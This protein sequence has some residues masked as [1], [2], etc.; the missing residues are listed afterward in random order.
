LFDVFPKNTVVNSEH[1]LQNMHTELIHL[2]LE[3]GTRTAEKRRI[4]WTA[5]NLR[6]ATYPPCL[7]DLALSA[8]FSLST[9]QL[10]EK[11]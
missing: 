4:C 9:L 8:F 1:S 5:N 10:I 11:E 7:L 3:S 6:F 2:L